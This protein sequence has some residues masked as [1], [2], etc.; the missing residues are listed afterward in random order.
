MEYDQIYNGRESW[1]KY[2]E[3]H[4]Q[5]IQHWNKVFFEMASCTPKH[6]GLKYGAKFEDEKYEGDYYILHIFREYLKL[7]DEDKLK[8][9]KGLMDEL[10]M[11]R[12]LNFTKHYKNPLW[13]HWIMQLAIRPSYLLASKGKYDHIVKLLNKKLE[14]ENKLTREQKDTLINISENRWES[15]IKISGGAD[16]IVQWD[17]VAYELGSFATEQIPEIISEDT[18][19]LKIVENEFLKLNDDD[20]IK[21]TRFIISALQASRS[22]RIGEYNAYHKISPAYLFAMKEQWK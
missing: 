21:V 20:K 1:K 15:H 3:K 10:R 2:L 12:K 17:K 16:K 8:V 5:N 6:E 18:E 14:N 19:Y 7:S 11:A 22:Q 4:G 9:V 13:Y